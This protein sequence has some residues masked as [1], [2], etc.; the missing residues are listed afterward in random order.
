MQ[1]INIGLV[2]ASCFYVFRSF[3]ILFYIFKSKRIK[4]NTFHR[5][6]MYMSEYMGKSGFPAKSAM[7]AFSLFFP[8]NT[9]FRLC[10][11]KYALKLF[12]QVWTSSWTSKTNYF[13]KIIRRRYIKVSSVVLRAKLCMILHHRKTLI[14]KIGLFHFFIFCIKWLFISSFTIIIAF[15]YIISEFL[16]II[17]SSHTHRKIRPT[18]GGRGPK[19]LINAIKTLQL[20]QIC[21]KCVLHSINNLK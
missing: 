14:I 16:I 20:Y 1:N 7:S 2:L 6:I 5:K 9:F 3:Y 4:L 10:Q 15:R 17:A 13:S 12:F 8:F 11:G 21:V 18:E 19:F